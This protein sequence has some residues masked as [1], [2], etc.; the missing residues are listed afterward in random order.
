MKQ[1]RELISN[2]FYLIELG[3]ICGSSGIFG[4]W[5]DV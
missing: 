3:F 1:Y 4:S 5:I 2:Y